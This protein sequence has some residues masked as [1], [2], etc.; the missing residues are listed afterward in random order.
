MEQ[1]VKAVCDLLGEEFRL[2]RTETHIL[3]LVAIG[4]NLFEVALERERNIETVRT[5]IK[6]IMQKMDEDRM[7]GIVLKVYQRLETINEDELRK[8]RKHNVDSHG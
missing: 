1:K 4:L 6:Q 8:L 2:T 5:Q 3:F 7:V